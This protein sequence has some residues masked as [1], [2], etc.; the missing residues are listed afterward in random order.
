M[1]ALLP[2]EVPLHGVRLIEANAGTG[3]TYTITTL[4]LRLLLERGLEVGQI[5]VVTYT[6]AATAELRR[7]VR[8][9]LVAM[10]DA[11][12]GGGGDA[13]LAELAE[14][15]RAGGTAARDARRLEAALYGSRRG[16]D[17]HHPRPLP[18]RPA[19][20]R[21]WRAGGVR[22]RAHRRRAPADRRR[23]ARLAGRELYA[24]PADLRAAGGR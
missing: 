8:E 4:Y 17:L 2:F 22:R 24:A 21:A 1:K 6:N 19:G 14:G 20:A 23:G 5:L 7:T 11:L 13:T 16:G 9:R 3:K 18:A 10:R 15:R 12:G